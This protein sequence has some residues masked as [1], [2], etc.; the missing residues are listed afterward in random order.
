MMS[1]KHTPHVH[2][3]S[4]QSDAKLYQKARA[5]FG[6]PAWTCRHA[7]LDGYNDTL[8]YANKGRVLKME[9]RES[10]ENNKKTETG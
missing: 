9:S 6:A 1:P 5:T 8:L 3:L 7:S 10:P 2:A 4:Q